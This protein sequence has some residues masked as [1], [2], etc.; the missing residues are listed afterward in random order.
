MLY[1]I[2]TIWLKNGKKQMVEHNENFDR[3]SDG[4]LNNVETGNFVGDE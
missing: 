4:D 1:T 2:M 3:K